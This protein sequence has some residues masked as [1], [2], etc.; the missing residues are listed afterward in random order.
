MNNHCTSTDRAVRGRLASAA[1]LVFVAFSAAARASS[2]IHV[3]DSVELQAAMVPANEGKRIVLARTEYVVSATLVVPKGASLVGGGRMQYDA[4]RLPAGI[5]DRLP[6]LR[7]AE[8]LSGDIL[9]LADGV[10]VSGL[11]VEEGRSADTANGNLVVV[12]S[13]PEA[14]AVSATIDEVDLLVPHPRGVGPTGPTRRG[15]VVWTRNLNGGLPPAPESDAL[16]TVR[17][18]NSIVRSPNGGTGIFV[19]NFAPRAA[20]SLTVSRNVIG[21][22][23]D[24]SGGTSR[25]DLVERSS[26][27][28]FSFDNHYRNDSTRFPIGVSLSGC[29]IAP[30]PVFASLPSVNNSLRMHSVHD[31]IE[32][33]G[34]GIYASGGLHFVPIG[35][36]PS[37]CRMEL[38]L[39]DTYIRATDQGLLIFGAVAESDGFPGDHN[40]LRLL[41]RGVHVEAPNPSVFADYEPAYP[42]YED[43]GNRLE[44]IGLPALQK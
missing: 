1:A 6:R 36:A 5:E 32:G 9:V 33:F 27:E 35:A 15:L 43:L 24:A 38:T 28:I 2:D 41:M 13:N 21:G 4:D 8:A 16:V 40:E 17:M 39:Q 22:G 14:T 30:V 3:A 25:G 11:V 42:A 12:Q 10:R 31:A 37:H 20:I 18:T 26:V 34:Y 7:S 44:V 29:A 19:N 23:L